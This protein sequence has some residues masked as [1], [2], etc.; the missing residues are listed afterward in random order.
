MARGTICSAFNEAY[1]KIHEA[2]NLDGGVVKDQRL[3]FLYIGGF[4]EVPCLMFALGGENTEVEIVYGT[5]IP[6]PPESTRYDGLHTAQAKGSLSFEEVTRDAVLEA[7]NS[8]A[9]AESVFG[10]S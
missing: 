3:V 6:N 10:T 7:V 9:R 4:G 5:A 8:W 2:S 1:L